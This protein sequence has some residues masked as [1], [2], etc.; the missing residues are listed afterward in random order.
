MSKLGAQPSRRRAPLAGTARREKPDRASEKSSKPVLGAI[1]AALPPLTLISYLMFYFGW[2][3]SSQQARDMGLD[4]ALFGYS[5]PDYVL[6]SLNTLTIPL[7]LTGGLALAWLAL[8]RFVQIQV[9]R[10]DGTESERSTTRRRIRVVG[11]ATI[12]AGL[13]VVVAAMI[14]IALRPA[15]MDGLQVPLVLAIATAVAAYGRWLVNAASDG[16][17]SE[18]PWQRGLYA[19]AI[20]VLISLFLVREVG[21]WA[22][23]EGHM[24]A[25]KVEQTVSRMPRVTLLSDRP[26]GI[27]APGVK[28][29]AVPDGSTVHYRTTGLRLLDRAGGHLF[30]LHD[31]WRR[32]DGITIVVADDKDVSWQLSH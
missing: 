12:A 25:G 1:V 18:E 27:D 31:G 23:V 10:R 32:R 8:H 7:L 5:T 13:L 14:V 21:N 6:R 20:G 29:E 19:L 9:D 24:Y 11:R 3:R 28:T 2:E 22:D 30:L 4:V 17:P 16:K 26:L 15:V